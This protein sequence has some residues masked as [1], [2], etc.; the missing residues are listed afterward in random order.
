LGRQRFAVPLDG[1][2][3][4]G[5][6]MFQRTVSIARSQDKSQQWRELTFVVFDAPALDAAF[7]ERLEFA[8][9]QRRAKA[10]GL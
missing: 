7:E 6:K 5:R 9:E 10:F 1:K 4:G 2:L 3:W 8:R